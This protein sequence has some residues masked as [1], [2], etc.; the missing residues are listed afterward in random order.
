M[1]GGRQ[2]K[3]FGGEKSGVGEKRGMW[4]GYIGGR[5]GGGKEGERERE[6]GR[7]PKQQNKMHFILPPTPPHTPTRRRARPAHSCVSAESPSNKPAW[8][9]DIAL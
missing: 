1:R 8:M 2:G 9:L 6:R 4:M 7:V 3:V 5:V